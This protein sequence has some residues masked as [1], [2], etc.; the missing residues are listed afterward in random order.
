MKLK[1]ERRSTR[2]QLHQKDD[3][4]AMLKEQLEQANQAVENLK[5]KK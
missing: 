4:I 1:Q 3:E 5:K 2:K